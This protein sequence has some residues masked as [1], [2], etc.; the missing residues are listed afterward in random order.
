MSLT[1]YSVKQWQYNTESETRNVLY[2]FTFLPALYV[3]SLMSHLSVSEE[4]QTSGDS[5]Q[6][7]Y[8]HLLNAGPDLIV[9]R[10][11]KMNFSQWH[12]ST[13]FDSVFRK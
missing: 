12:V 2:I 4:G 3:P 7:E 11:V 13:W 9:F 6:K 5:T 8:L 1:L 10:M